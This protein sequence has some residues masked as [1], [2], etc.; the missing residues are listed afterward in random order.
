MTEAEALVHREADKGGNR[1]EWLL[2]LEDVKFTYPNGLQALGGVSLEVAAGEVVSLVGPSGCG[3]STIISLVAGLNQPDGAVSWNPDGLADVDG[4][5]RRL[6][7]VVFQKNTV[8]PWLTVE[9]N[10][11]FGLKYLSIPASEKKRR[12]STLL[13]MVGLDEFRTAHPNELSG[14]MLRRVA[15]LTGVAT[16]PK[17]L[18][19]DEP[20]SALDEP[21]RILVHKDLLRLARELDMS[22]LLITHDLGEAISLSDQ[23]GIL[24]K[25]PARVAE[26][27]E[28]PL[29][30]DREVEQ[31]RA[32]PTYQELYQTLW[33]GLWKQIGRES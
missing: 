29:G 4:H 6:L 14:G 21:T 9:K 25:R 23:V 22:V 18:I 20:F 13:E 5:S 2:R 7:N 10:V 1:R 26:L 11:A 3:K 28:I 31:V 8:M 33:S 30:R 24:T 32:T 19:L 17:L 12:V 15:L 16:Y 27:H